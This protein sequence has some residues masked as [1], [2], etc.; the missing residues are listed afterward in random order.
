MA[1]MYGDS[2]LQEFEKLA[3]VDPD[4]AKVTHKNDNIAVEAEEGPSCKG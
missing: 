4:M 2:L 1:R 3:F